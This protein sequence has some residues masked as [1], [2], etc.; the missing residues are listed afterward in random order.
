MVHL[1]TALCSQVFVLLPLLLL[2]HLLY[3][4][5][6]PPHN[7]CCSSLAVRNYISSAQLHEKW[8]AYMMKNKLFIRL[9]CDLLDMYLSALKITKGRKN[10]DELDLPAQSEISQASPIC[11]ISLRF[12]VH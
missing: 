8:H 1:L 10:G 12:H 7:Y 3:V 9:L 4:V 5:T 11:G 2:M 6:S